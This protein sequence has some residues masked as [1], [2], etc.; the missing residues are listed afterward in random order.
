MTDYIT[1]TKEN[2]RKASN[3][4][5]RF[6]VAS[7]ALLNSSGEAEYRNALRRKRYALKRLNE[8]ANKSISNKVTKVI[9]EMAIDGITIRL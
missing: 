3:A 9:M 4:V 5:Y 2:Y 7:E 8:I 1:V 6:N